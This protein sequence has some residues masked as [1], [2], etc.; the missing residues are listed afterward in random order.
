M[1]AVCKSAGVCLP[2]FKSSPLHHNFPAKAHVAQ[3]AERVLGKDK[4]T[5]S[6]PV[7]GSRSITASQVSRAIPEPADMSV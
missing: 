7:V 6:I 2:R 4:V 1:G 5:G 3:S